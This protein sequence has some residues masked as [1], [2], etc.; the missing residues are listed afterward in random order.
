MNFTYFFLLDFQWILPPPFLHTIWHW[1][2]GACIA[3]SVG[4]AER[5]LV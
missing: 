1:A 2:S 4:T 5:P 3:L